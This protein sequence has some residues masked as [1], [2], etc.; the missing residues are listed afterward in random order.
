MR[1]VVGEAGDGLAVDADLARGGTIQ[2][3]D[4]IEERRL[5]GAGGADDG[6]HLAARDVQIDGFERSDLALAVVELGDTGE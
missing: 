5:S 1:V 6:D 4:Q 2:A 3:A